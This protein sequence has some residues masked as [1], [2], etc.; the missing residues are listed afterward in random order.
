MRGAI[1]AHRPTPMDTGSCRLRQSTRARARSIEEPTNASFAVFD[2]NLARLAS[3]AG[4]ATLIEASTAQGG[5]P[6]VTDN[7]ALVDAKTC[8]LEVW[9]R[10]FHNGRELWALPAC[11]PL[12]GLEL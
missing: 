1:C 6:L 11:N 5:Q 2:H 12:G 10:S 4:V 3:I 7:V 8:Q 9:V